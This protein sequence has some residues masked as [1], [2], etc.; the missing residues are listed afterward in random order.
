MDLLLSDATISNWKLRMDGAD[1]A[2]IEPFS[3]GYRICTRR[4]GRYALAL[5]H[6][7]DMN[8]D[9]WAAAQTALPFNW[10]VLVSLNSP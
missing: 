8:K 10:P 4:P 6:D 9:V 3:G 2:R 7:F 1:G 5:H